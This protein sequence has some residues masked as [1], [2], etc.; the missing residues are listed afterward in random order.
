MKMKMKKPIVSFKINSL[1][2]I[3]QIKQKVK[4]LH[5]HY[6]NL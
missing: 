4:C 2:I 1:M 5:L 3:I 6:N